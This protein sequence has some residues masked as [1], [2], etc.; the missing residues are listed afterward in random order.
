MDGSK[1]IGYVSMSLDKTGIFTD[2]SACIIAGSDDSM[3]RYILTEAPSSFSNQEI[4]KTRLREV[5]KGIEWGAEYQFDDISYARFK[6]AVENDNYFSKLEITK[7]QKKW[8][9]SMFYNVVLAMN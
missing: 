7:K 1:V 8:Y 2:G 3:K 6:E 4:K 5:M 9:G